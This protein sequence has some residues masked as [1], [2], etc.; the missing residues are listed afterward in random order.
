MNNKATS[1]KSWGFW[2]RLAVVMC[3]MVGMLL[4]GH[5]IVHALEPVEH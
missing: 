1:D 4:V 5:W 2:P 3:W